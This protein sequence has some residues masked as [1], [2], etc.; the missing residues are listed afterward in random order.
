MLQ[1]PQWSVLETTDVIGPHVSA[2]VANGYLEPSVRR[3]QSPSLR[4]LLRDAMNNSRLTQKTKDMIKPLI[5]HLAG[6]GF[7]E[8]R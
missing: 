6:G 8:V 5:S 3:G 4:D 7:F 1:P 2:P